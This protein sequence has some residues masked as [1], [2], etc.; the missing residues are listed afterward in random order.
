MRHE[1]L[2]A[3]IFNKLDNLICSFLDKPLRPSIDPKLVLSGHSAPVDELPPTACDVVEGSLPSCLDGAYIRNGPNPQFAPKGRPLHFFEGDGMLHMIKISQGKATFC[4][5]YVKTHKHLSEREAGYPFAIGVFS[6]FNGLPAA[7]A[8]L[9]LIG[10]RML[11]GQY[12]PG[13]HGSGTANVSVAMF[14]GGLF[15]LCEADIPY[16]LKV[17]KDGDIITLGRNRLQTNNN[18]DEQ[19]FLRMT[20]HPKVDPLTGEAFAYEY[21]VIRP[22]LTY[23]RID[24][25]GRKQKGVPISDV[26]GCTVIHDFGVT[27]NYAIF[28]D[29]QIMVKPVWVLSGKPPV[30]V[31]FDKVPRLG[32]IPRYALDDKGMWWVDAPGLNMM[33]CVNCWEE[34]GEIVLVGS[35]GL[36]VD[37]FL[38][39][40]R[41][42]ELRLEKIIINVNKRTV[43]RQMLSTQNL[44][45][46]NINQA[47]RAKKNRYVYAA[48]TNHTSWVGVVKLDLELANVGSGDC[49]I[50]SRLYGPDYNGGEPFFVPREPNNPSAD[51][52]DG[53]LVTYV[54][55]EDTQI[56]KFLVMDA[57]SPTLDIVVAVRLPQRVPD[58]FHGLFVSE[59][60]L[61]KL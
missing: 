55:D 61:A 53:Y 50:A 54:Y 19:P 46:G 56:S 33:H 24:P 13:N 52:D 38:E 22:F 45:L 32:I 16:Q 26:D 17:T 14:G 43:K 30:G 8:R 40:F 15:A 25:N 42:A 39:N 28:P 1:S 35:N 29:G 44:D 47:Y 41:Y 37:Q 4:S 6:S 5:R 58:G 48:I 18:K 3:N 31:D 27:E 49:T 23:F 34:K 60:D 12:D 20:A 51:E 36:V 21:D 57:K 10:A 9:L 2:L 59:S 7:M 11:S